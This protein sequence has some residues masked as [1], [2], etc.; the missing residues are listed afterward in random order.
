MFTVVYAISARCRQNRCGVIRFMTSWASVFDF[1]SIKIHMTKT[2]TSLVK[3]KR[4]ICAVS[5]EY[6]NL[7]FYR[8]ISFL[9]RICCHNTIFGWWRHHSEHTCRLVHLW[10]L[11]DA[12][13]NGNEVLIKYE[14]SSIFPILSRTQ[15]YLLAFFFL[16]NDS[17]NHSTTRTQTTGTYTAIS[18][19]HIILTACM[20][21][22][23][24][25]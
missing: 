6:Y 16:F 9:Y 19:I 1:V 4:L 11:P 23:R 13:P 22:V 7:L 8:E 5:Q 2:H 24:I 20:H 10:I 12:Q 21:A 17:F 15:T 14:I 25:V 3:K 18:F